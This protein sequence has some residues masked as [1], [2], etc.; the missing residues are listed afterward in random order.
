MQGRAI[1]ERVISFQEPSEET[2]ALRARILALVEEYHALAHA[3]KAFEAGASPVPVSGR[4]Y[5]ASDMRSLVASS[6]D[7]WL[8]PIAYMLDTLHTFCRARAA[9]HAAVWRVEHAPNRR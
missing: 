4:I 7:F 2:A 6:L 5:D 3:P 1:G 8:R 9:F